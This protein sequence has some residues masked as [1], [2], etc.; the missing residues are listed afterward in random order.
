M[1]VTTEMYTKLFNELT[2][3]TNELERLKEKIKAVQLETEEIYI[4]RID[5]KKPLFGAFFNAELRIKNAEFLLASFACSWI[6]KC[7]A[8]QP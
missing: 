6:K 2:N 4:N 7:V 8:F 1:E 5:W 3:I